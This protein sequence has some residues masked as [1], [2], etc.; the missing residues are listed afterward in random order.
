MQPAS[1]AVSNASWLKLYSNL[2]VNNTIQYKILLNTNYNNHSYTVHKLVARKI[3]KKPI[4]VYLAYFFI[5]SCFHIGSINLFFLLTW[6]IL[7][8]FTA[9]LSNSGN[10]A[11][12]ILQLCI[13]S[14][15]SDILSL[16]E[17]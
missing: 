15:S 9:S 5:I 12:T 16:D 13:E 4:T 10:E 7:V 17:R 14:A 8:S 11:G 3:K 6:L 1:G 2:K